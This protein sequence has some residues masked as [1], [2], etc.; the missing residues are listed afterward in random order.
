MIDL[1]PLVSKPNSLRVKISSPS[2][3]SLATAIITAPSLSI[4]THATR[5]M[6]IAAMIVVAV[7]RHY[8]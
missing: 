1:I 4:N 6:I 3:V 5:V 8:M 7:G 2:S